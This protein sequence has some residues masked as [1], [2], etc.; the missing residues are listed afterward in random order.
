[1]IIDYSNFRPSMQQL[2]AERVT[3]AGRYIGWNSEPGFGNPGHNIDKAE[4]DTLVGNEISVFLCFEYEAAAATKGSMQGTADGKLASKQLAELGAPAEMTVYFAIDFD[5]PDYAPN[6]TDPKTKL[7]PAADYFAAINALH[8]RYKVGVYG[9]YYAVSRAMDAGLAEM[10]WQ[11]VAWSGG[12]VYSQAVLLQPGTM[13]WGTNADVD[14][15]LHGAADFG[16]WPRPAQGPQRF[17]ADGKVSLRDAAK[18]HHLTVSQVLWAIA[19]H[20]PHG[21]ASIEAPYI[22]AG[23][24]D[25][26]MPAG[27]DYWA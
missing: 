2:K 11:T 7:G 19:Q 18:G 27:L 10:G 24:W 15:L 12:Q 23:Q 5:I 16:Q 21:Y 8:P 14:L 20:R 6:S 3:A 1:M 25:T 26:A 4:A 9:G 17:V 22:D 13:M